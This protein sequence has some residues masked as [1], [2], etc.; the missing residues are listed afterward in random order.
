[1]GFNLV[2]LLLTSEE[3]T[4]DVDLFLLIMTPMV[5]LGIFMI[6]RGNFWG[7]SEKGESE[8][9]KNIRYFFKWHELEYGGI[10]GKVSNYKLDD[11]LKNTAIAMTGTMF[12]ADRS[13]SSTNLEQLINMFMS[14]LIDGSIKRFTIEQMDEFMEVEGR[15]VKKRYDAFF[16]SRVNYIKVYQ[17]AQAYHIALKAVTKYEG[18]SNKE[19]S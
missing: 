2:F 9:V 11:L 13:Y 15:L 14:Q 5:A 1:M 12:T 17:R 8:Q 10:F 18:Q 7:N 4:L 3:W 19:D 16:V 6:Y